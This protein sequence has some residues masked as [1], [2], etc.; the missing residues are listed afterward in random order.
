M[1][2]GFNVKIIWWLAVALISA[3]SPTI[4]E[5]MDSKTNDVQFGLRLVQ[6]KAEDQ[7]SPIS[8]EQLPKDI[9]NQAENTFAMFLRPPALPKNAPA[10]TVKFFRARTPDQDD[11]V[12]F[13]W[14]FEKHQ[15]RAVQSINAMKLEIDLSNGPS[16]V[17]NVKALVEDIINTAGTDFGGKAYTVPLQWPNTLADGVSFSSNPTADILR[18]NRWCDRVDAIVRGHTLT[19]LFYKK[20]AQLAGYQAGSEWFKKYWRPSQP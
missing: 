3:L 14:T 17:E 15:L 6:D 12:E 16:G 7:F 18:L 11:L 13:E 5:A 9:R 1:R 20:I 8:I 4:T 19:V 2:P 10:V